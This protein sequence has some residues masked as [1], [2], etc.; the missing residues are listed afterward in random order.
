[1]PNDFISREAALAVIGRAPGGHEYDKGVD[2]SYEVV[3]NL[4]AADVAPVVRC[5]DCIHRI[6]MEHSINNKE[7]CCG[8]MAMR[9]MALDDYCSHG[10]RIAGG[11]SHAE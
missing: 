6:N 9:V 4:P 3:Q 5:R 2:Y 8:R 7:I 1:M 10:V 11:E